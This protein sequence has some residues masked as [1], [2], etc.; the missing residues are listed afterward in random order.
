MP[1]L[2]PA[3]PISVW[4]CPHFHLYDRTQSTHKH[5]YQKDCLSN[6]ASVHKL[7]TQRLVV[8][9]TNDGGNRKDTMT[10]YN[11]DSR[12]HGNML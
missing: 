2:F 12:C 10:M 6:G 8:M 11:T 7:I 5:I 4:I 1:V 3:R 9:E